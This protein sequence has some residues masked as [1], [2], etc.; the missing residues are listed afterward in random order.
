MKAWRKISHSLSRVLG[1]RLAQIGSAS[2]CTALSSQDEE[3]LMRTDVPGEALKPFTPEVIKTMEEAFQKACD[4][5]QAQGN[6]AIPPPQ[7]REILGLRI[8]ETTAR[9]IRDRD[10]LCED[11]IRYLF[12]RQRMMSDR[13][14]LRPAQSSQRNDGRAGP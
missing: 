13:K 2:T 14:E 8:I 11:A 7:V 5:A 4:F 12:R 6:P 1:I 9:G 3:N 10:Y